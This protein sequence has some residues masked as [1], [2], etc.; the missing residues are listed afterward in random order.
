MPSLKRSLQSACGKT[1][2]AEKVNQYDIHVAAL[3]PDVSN[4]PANAACTR[5]ARVLGLLAIGSDWWQVGDTETAGI[6][7]QLKHLQFLCKFRLPD[8]LEVGPTGQAFNDAGSLLTARGKRTMADAQLTDQLTNKDKNGVDAGDFVCAIVPVGADISNGLSSEVVIPAGALNAVAGTIVF[9]ISNFTQ[10]E[11]G[12]S[13]ET[14]FAAACGF[15]N[16][17]DPSK[18][19]T[20]V[21]PMTNAVAVNPA[22]VPAN[23]GG[24]LSSLWQ[25]VRR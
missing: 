25:G 21:I 1:A 16:F 22:R 2:S 13:L 10:R 8:S 18:F 12:A 6:T 23:M 5:L 20:A 3:P 11:G 24:P 19:I 14:P 4:A 9:G 15:A 7:S 17:G